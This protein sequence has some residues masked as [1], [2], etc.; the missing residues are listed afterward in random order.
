MQRASRPRVSR[1]VSGMLWIPPLD[2]VLER[3]VAAGEL[4][5]CRHTPIT[6]MAF[7]LYTTDTSSSRIDANQVTYSEI[8]SGRGFR[9]EIILYGAIA[10]ALTVILVPLMEPL[11]VASQ[12]VDRPGGHKRHQRP[13]PVVGGVA[14]YLALAGAAFALNML[15]RSSETM[16]AALAA[17]GMLVLMGAFD[18]RQGLPVRMRFLI[19]ILAALLVV[20]ASGQYLASLGNLFGPF[21]LDLILPLGLAVTVLATVGGINAMN[22][23]DGLDGLSG[24][25]ALVTLSALLWAAAVAGHAA[26]MLPL[27]AV[28]GAV[29]GF[30][31]FNAR[32]GRRQHA[33]IFMGD[34]G[35]MLLGF[36]ITWFLIELTQGPEAVLAPVVA[37][38]VYALP[39]MDT[40]SV[41]MHR[42]LRGRSPFQ[43]GND[44]IHHMLLAS[45][46][47]ISRTVA[48][49]IGVQALFAIAGLA[50]YYAGLP[51]WV[52][53]YGLMALFSAYVWAKF[54]GFFLRRLPTLVAVVLPAEAGQHETQPTPASKAKRAA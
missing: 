11:A 29:A 45:G 15:P 30:L 51:A 37:L 10:F 16:V 8:F 13:T 26:T 28:W 50:G 24:G 14:I 53:F 21:A 46:L 34:A 27:L 17:G 9:V 48:V 36:L 5:P 6:S 20:W 40:L 41:M 33:R 43:P 54:S 23:V 42:A 19:Q 7:G 25:L 47:S 52:M 31:V 12:L 1:C 39:L 4:G 22:M 32:I 2:F 44:H 18:D 49:L 38:W 3:F 35:S